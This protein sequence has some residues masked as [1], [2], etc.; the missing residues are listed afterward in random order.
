M[1]GTLQVLDKNDFRPSARKVGAGGCPKIR[2]SGVRTSEKCPPPQ[3]NLRALRARKGGDWDVWVVFK[4]T[5]GLTV[6]KNTP[7]IKGLRH[8]LVQRR[9]R[10]PHSV[11][12]TASNR[13]RSR[14]PP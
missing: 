11:G 3:K 9:R 7:S 14:H 2:K 13:P 6:C 1:L 5:G 4:N 8:L 10:P 12:P